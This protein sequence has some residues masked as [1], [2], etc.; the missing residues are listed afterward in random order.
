MYLNLLLLFTITTSLL[1]Q[2]SF[3]N[4]LGSS[5]TIA[6]T[7]TTPTIYGIIAGEPT[8]SIKCYTNGQTI[9]IQPNVSFEAIS[10]G[11][12]FFC[13]LKSG[14]FSVFCWERERETTINFQPKR[15]YHSQ[16]IPLTDLTVGVDHVCAREMN[17]GIAK[18][19][20][21]KAHFPSP[22]LGFK[23]KTLTSGNGF[24]CG[25]LRNSSHVYCWG[26]NEIA[27]EIQRQLSNLTM[28]SL[29]AGETHVC[30]LKNNGFLI[31]K[32][33]NESGQLQVPFSSAFEYSG[34]AL[35][36]DFSCAIKQR[37]G[38]LTC[39]GDANKFQLDT[40][41]NEPLELI[42]AGFDF[43][44]GLKTNN[45]SVI[46]RGS[47]SGGSYDI[48]LGK[49][50]PGPCLQSSCIECGLYPDSQVLCGGG[51]RNMN[52][53]KSCQIQL[54]IA[55]PLPPRTEPT[56]NSRNKLSLAF[57][58]VGSVGTF[59]GFCTVFYCFITFLCR[60][61]HNLVQPSTNNLTPAA[62]V[63][64][65]NT[66][67]SI[68]T[69]SMRSYSTRRYSSSRIGRQRSESSSKLADKIQNFC[70]SELVAATDNFSLANKIGSGSFGIV[71]K[72]RLVDG[73][74]VAIKRG[75]TK[76]F[77][78]K[79]SAFDSELA[80]L[81]R[82]H[83]KHLVDLIGFCEEGDE[84]LLVYEYMSNG[85]LHDHLHHK[86]NVG[87]SS[88]FLN[89]WK[90]RIKIAL[91]AARGIEYLHN[92]A[93]PPIIHRDIKS[94][95]IL[96]DKNWSARVSD[97]GLSLMGPDSDGEFMSTKAVGTV[98]YIDPEYYVLNVLTAK[99][100]VYGLGV[101]LL[102]LLTG[103]KAVFKNEEGSPSAMEVVEYATPHISAG[104]LHKV[105]DKRVGSPQ[106]QEAEAVELMAH[107]AMRCVKLE[108][109][110]RPNV[111]D[112]VANLERALA[113]CECEET[114]ASLS[115]NTFSIPSS[116]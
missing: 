103:K 114:P 32:G 63:D 91:D 4:S 49:I 97:F 30:G 92:Y 39:W 106:I 78:D 16:T 18:C 12:S 100:D 101:V 52:I 90:V 3:L 84:R 113:I 20:R 104:E 85:A 8:Q 116:D 65:T 56:S 10:G 64:L 9:S 5:S 61:R 95:N 86:N 88:S 22:G 59:A 99:S 110:E 6:I 46:C 79:E 53:C 24:T 29:V 69:S 71:Y 33:S 72:G 1:L 82:L 77:Q 96:L 89:S 115:P 102:E 73:R 25:I 28:L 62:A 14:G 81:S 45:L 19:W 105:L 74:G 60:K 111:V 112:I 68:T 107:T 48:Q 109:R 34:I 41:S 55:V 31:C 47:G 50:L 43:I 17:S 26:N 57:L 13:A 108:G 80:L 15:I 37:N 87:K 67:T 2:P 27:A 23:F 66:G 38:F 35:G 36:S 98:G 75:E 54:P 44:C 51:S 70:L 7:Y 11:N 40:N 58:I 83:H 21:G 42:V 76:K 93:V 94:S